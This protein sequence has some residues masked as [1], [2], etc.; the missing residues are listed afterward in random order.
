[1]KLVTRLALAALAALAVSPLTALAQNEGLTRDQVKQDLKQVEQ[2]GYNPS[3]RDAY[4]PNNIQ[5]AEQKVHS[6]AAYGASSDGTSAS[7]QPS[8][9]TRP[10]GQN[11]E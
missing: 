10:P 2:A 9:P 8:M 11:A 1:M 6:N 5:A 3:E 4:Y 7:G